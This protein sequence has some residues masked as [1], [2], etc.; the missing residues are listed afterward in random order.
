MRRYRDRDDYWSDDDGPTEE[1]RDA[2]WAEADA[3]W[4]TLTLSDHPPAGPDDDDDPPDDTDDNVP[5]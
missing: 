4:A 1:E 5:F 3:A 2:A